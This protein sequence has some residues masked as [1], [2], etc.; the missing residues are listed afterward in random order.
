MKKS[1][2]YFKTVHGNAYLYDY[3]HKMFLNAPNF[4]DNVDQIIELC[5]TKDIELITSYC[6]LNNCSQS[7]LL[8]YLEE[9]RFLKEHG[10][11]ETVRKEKRILTKIYP[12]TIK[13][14]L[15]KL[16]HLVFEVTESCNLQCYYCGY[17]SLYNSVIGRHNTKFPFEKAKALIDYL[18]PFW[19]QDES[20][21]KAL[22][23]SF[24]GGEPLL[25]ISFIK[26]V[27]DYLHEINLFDSLRFSITTNGTLLHHYI[28]YLVDND[29][30]VDVSLDGNKHDNRYRVDKDM[31]NSFDK[32]LENLNII[33]NQYPDFFSNNVQFQAVLSQANSVDSITRFFKNE[34]NKSVYILE[35]NTSNVV[36]KQAF[37]AVFQDYNESLWQASEEVKEL[38]FHKTPELSRLGN[39]I[40]CFLSNTWSNFNTT[41]KSIMFP[42]RS[43]LITATCTPLWKKMFVTAKGNIMSCERINY[44]YVIG[45]IADNGEVNIDFE[46]V[47][48]TYNSYYDSLSAQCAGCYSSSFCSQCM[49]YIDGLREN[50]ICEDCMSEQDACKY[51]SYIFSVFENHP[52]M[53]YT[54]INCTY[55]E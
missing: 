25:N 28:K 16:K 34:F 26:N 37:K 5:K 41:P 29:F 11:F 53:V 49:F 17:G 4:F 12:E 30:K 50:A 22:N 10:F 15:S 36:D 2:I 8:S 6:K 54:L 52:D 32:V 7:D 27:V 45:K 40:V 55:Y 51:M 43:K 31:T 47:A 19:Q 38:Y 1:T 33:R 18:V 9:V 48:N 39:T 21:S 3:N 42:K 23:V 44:D 13:M 20:R 24:Y 35:I 46:A 14:N